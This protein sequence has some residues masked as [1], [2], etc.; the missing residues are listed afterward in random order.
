MWIAIFI[1]WNHIQL[2]NPLINIQGVE[3]IATYLPPANQT[4]QIVIYPNGTVLFPNG[5][6]FTGDLIIQRARMDRFETNF[7]M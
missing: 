2:F 7:T 6:L 4:D 3:H 5:T 1:Y